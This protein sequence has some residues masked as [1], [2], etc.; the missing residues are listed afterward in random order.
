MSLYIVMF[1]NSHIKKISIAAATALAT[2]GLWDLKI[3]S[4][5]GERES[6]I[7]IPN[8]PTANVLSEISSATVRP[9]TSIQGIK[10]VAQVLYPKS[11]QDLLTVLQRSGHSISQS[12]LE[13][14]EQLNKAIASKFI[15]P[16]NN[17][18]LQVYERLTK[19]HR[20][21]GSER[22]AMT[23]QGM[24][25]QVVQK[26]MPAIKDYFPQEIV[27]LY[28]RFSAL[29][30][31]SQASLEKQFGGL[32]KIYKGMSSFNLKDADIL[33][34]LTDSARALV[35]TNFIAPKAELY[36]SSR[37]LISD[38]ANIEIP[39]FPKAPSIYEAQA[40]ADFGYE[41]NSLF[42]Q[43][44]YCQHLQVS[45]QFLESFKDAVADKSNSAQ[46]W[47]PFK[48][49]LNDVIWSYRELRHPTNQNTD[50][51]KELASLVNTGTDFS[52]KDLGR[53]ASKCSLDLDN[54]SERQFIMLQKLVLSGSL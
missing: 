17:D 35:E 13:F 48:Q 44:D 3:A 42:K 51:A 43:L 27:D 24:L 53:L 15:N 11:L 12:D 5:S 16:T 7:K 46:K 50:Y 36:N 1:A 54:L 2:A 33:K 21:E 32:S 19:W 26:G 47:Q 25:T 31:S 4:D 9:A 8:V 45:D 39:E 49:E 28:G 18:Y 41:L 38:R 6:S 10:S 40:L 22:I 37:N 34:N 52:I 23:L 30:L 29:D 20:S 14:I